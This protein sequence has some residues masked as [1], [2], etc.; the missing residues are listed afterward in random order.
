MANDPNQVGFFVGEALERSA[1]RHPDKVALIARDR[2]MKFAELEQAATR[3][4]AHMQCEGVKHGD[5]VGLMFPN[6][7]AF[8]LSYY[9]T[10]KMGAVAT[11]M[12]ARLKG[13]ELEGVLRDGDLRLLISYR[14]IISE[15][16]ETLSGFERLPR[17]IV[18]GEGDECFEKRLSSD[19]S[20]KFVAPT[21]AP[22]QDAV[23]LYTSGTTGEPKGVVLNHINLAQFPYCM[24]E[25]F[26]TDSTEVWGCILPMSHISGPIYCNEIVDKGSTMVIFDQINPISLLEGIQRFGVTIYHGVPPIFQLLL[27]AR[28]L[29]DYDTHSVKFVGMM[30]TTVPLSLMRAFKVAQPHI[31]VI[32]GYGLTETSPIITFV[33]LERADEKLGSIGRSVPGVEVKLVNEKGEEVAE[34]EI[35]TRGPH[36]MKG[37]F[38]R[39][40]ATAERIHNGWLYTGDIGRR[41]E[42]GYYYHLGRKDDLIITGGMN[43]Y[44]AEVE[45]LLCEHPQVHEAAVFPI[46]DPGRGKVLGAAVV[47][48]PGEKIVEKEIL[49]FLRSNLANFKVPQKITIRDSLPRTATGKVKRED[50]N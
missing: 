31:K 18:D 25:M 46:P 1:T 23:I 24:G 34:G 20:A 5:R 32:Q 9:A 41:D 37:Y 16:A 14:G 19:A 45:N 3:L 43:V 27:G 7:L 49:G 13:K 39:P 26:K 30:G 28:N 15:N 47:P 29:K 6:S 4:A 2:E 44:P 36:V 12:D 42:D 50:M 10:Q 35:I 8:A 48:R 21:L 11:I 22:E 38:R 33:E 17:W 40:E